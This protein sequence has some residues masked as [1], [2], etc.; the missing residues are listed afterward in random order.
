MDGR[1]APSVREP[2]RAGSFYPGDADACARE[3]DRCLA[4]GGT[5]P[6]GLLGGIAPHA[7]WAFSGPTAGRLFRALAD[8][9]RP[10]RS[11]LFFG[12]VHTAGAVAPALHPEGAWRTPLGDVPVDAEL[13]DALRREA[14]DLL[15]VDARPHA[16]EHS[17]EVLVPLA[18]RAI[19]GLAISALA[20]PPAPDAVHLGRAAARAIAALDRDVAFVAST[21]LT[22]YG[23]SYYGFAPMGTG[24]EALRWVRDENDAR[25]VDRFLRLDAEG[26]LKEAST[27][28]SAC[29]AG[30][31]AAAAACAAAL[32]AR[33]GILLH[34][35]TSHDARPLG[36]PTDFVGYAAVAFAGGGRP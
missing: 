10:F 32:G 36:P 27:H 14:A 33:R 7:G 4:A 9:P 2:V 21:D 1:N 31:A 28:H 13:N 25:M 23:A 19:P 12:A 5:A 11:V 8:A 3:A 20:V 17:V 24:E 22:H 34:Y 29:G 35:T 15:R 16:R 18:Q 26:I 30:A 6:E